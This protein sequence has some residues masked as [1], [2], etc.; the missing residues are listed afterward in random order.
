MSVGLFLVA[1]IG[2]SCSGSSPSP[3]EPSPPAA[4]P[5]NT[6]WL[7]RPGLTNN[8][9]ETD[10]TAWVVA[11]DGASTPE[12]AVLAK[13]P[14][15]DCFYLYP[16]VSGQST[17]NANLQIDPEETAVAIQQASR[18]SQVCKVYAPMYRQRTL[19]AL[20]NQVD[21]PGIREIAYGDVLSAWQDYMARYNN[22]RGFVLIGHSQGARMLT[23][24]V[25]SEIDPDP[26][27]RGHLVSAL[28]VGGNVMVASSRD[29]GGD[30]QN[31]PACRSADQT[32]CVVAYS[33]FNQTPPADSRFG[34]V[35]AGS[36]A[37]EPTKENME[38]LCVN[39]A[40]LSGGS[41]LLKTYFY[42]EATASAPERW[43][44][45]L[46]LYTGRC[47]SSGGINWLQVDPT[48]IASDKRVAVSQT[49]GPT[50]GLHLYDVNLAL[51][52][53]VDLVRQQAAVFSR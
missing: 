19:T 38:V 53:L 16:T 21:S 13:E 3:A 52:N 31:V 2:I 12:Q 28:I 20:L 45:F 10:S 15:I 47:E 32:G 5:S 42:L 8:P 50:W 27:L 51:G 14:P 46:D 24:L 4:A 6:V 30:F 29:V 22:G 17:P 18:F 43:E 48:N 40:S 35:G 49:L 44:A 33:A 11:A 41:G 26:E 9:C 34:K 39:P 7:C 25:A 37:G 23:E 36:R 1:V